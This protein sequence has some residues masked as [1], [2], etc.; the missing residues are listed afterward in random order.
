LFIEAHRFL[1]ASIF[2]RSTL[3]AAWNRI[4]DGGI[5]LVMRTSG[6]MVENVPLKQN[7][8]APVGEVTAA[9]GFHR[10]QRP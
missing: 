1:Q 10:E 8:R 7:D 5:G 4:A 2:R 3:I 9:L 6:L